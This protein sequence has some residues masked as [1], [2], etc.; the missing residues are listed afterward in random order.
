MRQPLNNASAA[1][2][3]SASALA[4]AGAGGAADGVRLT[5]ARA[6][7]GQ[8]I[9][10]IDNTL[11]VAALLARGDPIQRADTD[12]DTR[13]AVAIADM[14]A[15]ERARVYIERATRTRTASMDM[16]LMRLALRNLLAN[17]LKYGAPQMPVMVRLADSDEP[18]A[19]VI[20]VV[21]SGRAIAAERIGELFE[22]AAPRPRSASSGG[23]LGLGLYIV[24]R[25]MELHGGRA[26]LVDN[27]AAG[28]TMRLLVAQS[29]AD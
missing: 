4:G 18:L 8:V 14:P 22:R 20:D 24:R 2:Q 28:V 19:L 1:L 12:I 21:S 15:G 27:S 5:R 23:G 13:V 29:P 26:E 7:I 9:A 17:A 11:A 25:V 3:L 6:V 16:S 10:S